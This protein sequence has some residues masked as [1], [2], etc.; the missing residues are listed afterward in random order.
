MGSLV[1]TAAIVCPKGPSVR[2]S[3]E[4]L[5]LIQWI[6]F[7]LATFSAHP[8]NLFCPSLFTWPETACSLFLVLLYVAWAYTE[9]TSLVV[10]FG[11]MFFV[12]AAQFHIIHPWVCVVVCEHKDKSLFLLIWL[13]GLFRPQRNCQYS[14]TEESSAIWP[15]PTTSTGHSPFVIAGN[16]LN[17]WTTSLIIIFILVLLPFN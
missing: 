2:P 15:Q 5:E 4:Q 7:V 14:V 6:N 16:S 17:N 8:W 13:N 9:G 10:G 12:G 1:S 11:L 3:I